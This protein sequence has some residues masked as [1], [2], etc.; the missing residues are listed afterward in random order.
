MKH[1]MLMVYF[2]GIL[3]PAISLKNLMVLKEVSIFY[4]LAS[5]FVSVLQLERL[6]RCQ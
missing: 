5:V 2:R 1:C 4:I 3:R 6:N